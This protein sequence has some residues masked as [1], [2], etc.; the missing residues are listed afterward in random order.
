MKIGKKNVLLNLP[1]NATSIYIHKY[2]C[3]GKQVSKKK[4]H[5]KFILFEVPS[6]DN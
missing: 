1:N 4:S 2:L 5:E 6:F 3:F